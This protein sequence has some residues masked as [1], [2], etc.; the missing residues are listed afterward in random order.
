MRKAL[1]VG[2]DEYPTGALTGCVSDASLMAEILATHHDGDPNFDCHLLTAP[3][4]RVERPDL[5]RA[6]DELFRDPAE[7]ALLHFSGHGTINDLGGYLVTQDTQRYD[8]GVSMTEVLARANDSKVKE[9]VIFL[10]CCHS[11]A[12]GKLPEI[13]NATAVLRE[14]VSILT[15]SRGSQAAVEQSGHG[16]VTSMV[17]DALLGGAADVCG[18]VSIAGVYAYVDQRLGPWHQRPLFKSHVSTLIPL[19]KCAPHVERAILRA[20]PTLFP[21]ADFEKPLDPSY[22]PTAEPRHPENERTF[23]Q[24]Q[25]LASARLLVPIGEE[26]MYYAA[27]NSKACALTPLGKHYWH[28]AKARRI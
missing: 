28:L 21:T 26:H 18:N 22:E 8:E 9:V 6:L 14:G 27:M 10:D 7:V 23:G 25:R 11:G 12:L 24:L 17:S 4:E 2:I 19:R 3:T 15:A 5:R 1:L 13:N 20:L 16:L